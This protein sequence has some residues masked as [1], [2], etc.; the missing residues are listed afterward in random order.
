MQQLALTGKQI[1]LTGATGSLGKETALALAT[2]GASL[3]LPVRN[4]GKAK[5][6]ENDLLKTYPHTN[7]RFLPLDMADESSVRSLTRQL[8]Q[9]KQPLDAVIHNAGVFTKAN[10]TTVQ[11]TEWHRQVNA[12]SPLLLTRELLPLLELSADPAVVTVTSLS[13]FWLKTAKEDEQSLSPTRLYAASKQLMLRHMQEL[14]RQHPA[15]RFVYAH[16]GVCA[17]GLFTGTTHPTAYHAT[18]LKLIL[19]L[20]KWLFPNPQ[21]ACRTT[22]QAL[23]CGKEG[24]LSEPAG[25]LHIWGKPTLTPLP[26]RLKSLSQQ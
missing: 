15:I 14:S 17:T 10:L 3:L 22:L 21:K 18:L 5:A 26:N 6:L 25:L 11:G 20:M 23:T 1:L 16:P 12:L 7:V 24:Q 9:E 2:Q 19:P 13:A 4:P 8:I